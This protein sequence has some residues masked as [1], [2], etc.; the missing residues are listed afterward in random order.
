MK[1]IDPGSTG[2][3]INQCEEVRCIDVCIAL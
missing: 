3:V 2:T 1:T